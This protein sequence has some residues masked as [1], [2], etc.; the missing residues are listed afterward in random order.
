MRLKTTL[1]LTLAMAGAL[2]AA[3][4][5]HWTGTWAT[6]PSPQVSPEQMR[7]RKLEFKDQTIR[8]VVHT[9]I[10]GDT[11]R[12]RL[13]NAFGSQAVDIGAAHIALRDSG[14][15]IV[16]TS[17]HPLTFSG[18][19]IVKIP[20]NAI[21]LSD[22][23]K[24]DVP[25][26]GDLTVSIYIPDTALGAGVHYS[27]QQT[28][29]VSAGDK[30]A[31]AI[32]TEPTPIPSWVFLTGVDV[33]APES[34]GSIVAIGDSITDGARS[35]METNHR[36]PNFL[37]TRLASHKGGAKFSVVNMGIGGNRI[38]TDAGASGI[39]ALARFE[40]D[41]LAQPGVR[42]VIILEGINDIGHSGPTETPVSADDLIAGLTQMIER[43]H[44]HGI[45]VIGAT[46]TPF[47]GEAQ[48][49]RGYY[50]PEK[51]KIRD[52]V[53]QWIRTAKAYDGVIDFDKVVRDPKNPTRFLPAFDSGDQLHPGD[54][55]YEAMGEAIDLKLFK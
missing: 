22:P 39:N 32:L 23:V 31:A 14:S 46:L 4:Q 35:S 53:N 20:A 33:L 11:V 43:A 28:S 47:E 29:W 19:P 34:A 10:G 21:V 49:S 37:A 7:T 41:V 18:R 6:A 15:G 45:K 12:V 24:L 36:W 50:T 30:T 25:P 17:D 27:S 48:S 5:T 55:G 52:A 51:A 3:Q 13:S 54:A 38:L 1:L 2:S 9:S 16:V 8:E 44:E 42:Y 26:G 40:T